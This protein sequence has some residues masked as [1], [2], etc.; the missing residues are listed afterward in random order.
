MQLIYYIGAPMMRTIWTLYGITIVIVAA[1]LYAQL[2][3]RRQW[4][5]ITITGDAMMT[6]SVVSIT[7]VLSGAF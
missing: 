3:V 2:T 6:L 4:T 1:R 5:L 7:K